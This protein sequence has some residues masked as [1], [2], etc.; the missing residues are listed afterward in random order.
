MKPTKAFVRDDRLFARFFGKVRVGNDCWEWVGAGQTQGYGEYELDGARYMAHRAAYFLGTG[1]QPGSLCVCHRCDNPSCVRPSHLFLGTRRDNH[2]DMRAKGRMVVNRGRKNGMAKLRGE[3]IPT[4]RAL[5]R[6][7]VSLK[8]IGRRFGVH[9]ETIRAVDR[10]VT[11]KHIPSS[12][13]LIR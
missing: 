3:D 13:E 7:G 11:W 8:N 1:E 6:R 2:L 12:E 4:I 5:L 10:G 9:A